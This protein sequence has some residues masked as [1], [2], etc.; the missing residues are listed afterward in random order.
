LEIAI[1]ANSP[2]EIAGWTM[3]VLRK[4]KE[5]APSAQTSILLLPCAF[6][7]GREYEAA[8]ALEGADRVLPVKETIKL[9]LGFSREKFDPDTRLLHLGGD[10]FYAALLSR[11]L[12]APAWAYEWAQK[13]WDGQF[14]GYFARDEKNRQNLLDRHIPER[15]I[16]VVGDLLVDSVMIRRG[17]S[18]PGRAGEGLTVTFMPGSRPKE[19]LGLLPL[20]AGTAEI[21]SRSYPGSRFLVPLSPFIDRSLLERQGE[22]KPLPDIPGVPIRLEG[23]RLITPAGVELL[24]M[25]DSIR[26]MG[27]ADFLVSIPGTSTGEAGAMGVPTFCILPINRPEAIPFVGI[28]GLLDVIPFAGKMLK[29]K[30]MLGLKDKFGLMAQPNLRAKREIIPEAKAVVDPGSLFDLINP[31]LADREKREAMKRELLSLYAPLAGSAGAVAE[32]ILSFDRDRE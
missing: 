28:I 19:L 8:R 14:Q 12:S 3:P 2:G 9:I 27:Q 4:L 6:A 24:V 1:T 32:R 31:Y 20:F 18:L 16:H 5:L 13:K 22:I 26:A 15:K 23:D 30:L 25:E 17:D 7:S 21:I 10:L 29:R 11:R